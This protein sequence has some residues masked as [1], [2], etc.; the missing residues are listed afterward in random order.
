MMRE[1]ES[2]GEGGWPPPHEYVRPRAP[3][4]EDRNEGQDA[5][6]R[7]SGASGAPPPENGYQDT[8]A[9][10][11][12]PGS[13]GRDSQGSYVQ[14]S[15]G[16]DSYGQD[17]YGQGGYGQ[18]GYGNRAGQ[19]GQ[20]GYGNQDAH[21]HQDGAGNQATWYGSQDGY[22]RQHDYGQESYQSR[23]ER[24]EPAGHQAGGGYGA[25]APGWG[26]PDPPPGRP[27]RGGR[28]LVYL[29]VAALAA[30]IGAGVTVALGHHGAAPSGG[31]SSSNVPGPGNNAAGSGSSS[32]PFSR[33]AAAKAADKVKPGLVDITSTLKYNSET[34]EGTGMIISSSGLVLTNNHVIDGATVV[35][36]ALV[37]PGD[38]STATYSAQVVGYDATDDV[39]LLQLRNAS[40]LPTENFGNSSQVSLGTP[41]VALGNAEGRGGAT[42]AT[43]IINALNRSIQASDQG[44]NTTED[45][46]HMLQTDAR[47]QQGDSGGALANNAGQV[48]G[49]ITAA[50]ASTS[51]Q[52]GASGG[53]L[54]FAIPINSALAIARQIASGQRSATVYV[55]MPGF[56]GVEV[57]T[58]SSSNP[59][60]QAADEA[61]GGGQAALGGGSSCQTTNQQA[62]VPAHIAPIAAGAL[63]LGVLCNTAAASAGMVPGDVI[64]SVAGQ[65]ISTPDSLTTITARYHPNDVV[66]VIWVSLDGVGHTTRM[67]L[68]AGPA[69]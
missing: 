3:R 25:P 9:F 65:P 67:M 18:G 51:S 4:D 47:I 28:F 23:G 45:L 44:S 10:G 15:Y 16:Q 68:G 42:P 57:A 49:M 50:N 38:N 36:A 63:I 59:Q 27:G 34:A 29:T 35:Q 52:V 66:S 2:D 54:G 17:S 43:G 11:T 41:V 8:I 62:G 40:G 39:A 56:L 13:S 24:G 61:Q 6:T 26:R 5:G 14:G 7:W 1:N 19:G 20:A 22:G 58:S 31:I 30:G 55:G 69:R 32:A 60:Q 37:A 46:N 48:I 53:T 12:P 33:A 64:T 21:G